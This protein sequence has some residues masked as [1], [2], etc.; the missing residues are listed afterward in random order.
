MGPNKGVPLGFQQ[1]T[2][3]QLASAVSLNVPAGANFAVISVETAA[4][5]F[6]DD[7][8]APTAA[9]G[10]LLVPT[11]DGTL[12]FEYWG[13]LS[14]IQFIAQTGSPIVNVSYYKNAG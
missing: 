13:N 7:G 10:V 6:R 14:A 2:A 9:I 3:T 1:L 5:R 12:P 11:S 4:V 8:A